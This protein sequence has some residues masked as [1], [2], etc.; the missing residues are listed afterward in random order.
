M[1]VF[2]L[3]VVEITVRCDLVPQENDVETSFFTV[4][5]GR[6]S[7][8]SLT[9]KIQISLKNHEHEHEGDLSHYSSCSLLH[10]VRS[11]NTTHE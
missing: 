7:L 6:F 9:C 1:F 8:F 4:Y 10:A 5:D 3:S 11:S 2:Q